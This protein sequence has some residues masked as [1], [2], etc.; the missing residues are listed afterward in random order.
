MIIYIISLLKELEVD[1]FWLIYAAAIELIVVDSFF[2]A[3]AI[4]AFMQA[5]VK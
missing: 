5:G 4:S 3:L 2:I 1:Y